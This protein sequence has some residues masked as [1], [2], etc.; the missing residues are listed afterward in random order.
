MIA[1]AGSAITATQNEFQKPSGVAR[2]WL[3]PDLSK[4][5]RRQAPKIP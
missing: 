4:C 3:R 2:K 1:S 5:S